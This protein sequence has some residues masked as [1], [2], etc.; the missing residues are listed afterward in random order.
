MEI[1][2]K[3]KFTS[4]LKEKDASVEQRRFDGERKR[5]YTGYS[6]TDS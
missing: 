5:V 6:L 4:I 3:H 1:V 2:T